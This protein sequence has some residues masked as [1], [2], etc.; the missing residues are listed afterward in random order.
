[1]SNYSLDS[2]ERFSA[3]FAALSNRH[4]LQIFSQLSGCRSRQDRSNARSAAACCVGELG[5]ALD[6]AA[7]TLSHHLKELSHAGLIHMRREGRRVV[8]S[9]NSEMLDE[10]R[11]Y[12][13][14]NPEVGNEPETG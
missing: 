4:R 12:F 1:M 6:I 14:V 13:E 5:S 10:L 11:Q 8:C 9:V 2:A 3:A 7:S